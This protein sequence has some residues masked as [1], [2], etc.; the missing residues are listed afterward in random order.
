MGD[1]S[2]YFEDYP[3]ENPG[4]YIDGRYDPH[5]A[6]LARDRQKAVL[7][8]NAEIKKILADAWTEEKK[9]SFVGTT[10]CP[11]CGFVELYLYD[12]KG[13]YHLCE[14]QEC[15]I[16]G[17]GPSLTD[18]L[19]ATSDAIGEG[20]EWRDHPYPFPSSHIRYNKD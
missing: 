2:D 12:I 5:G 4:N 15:G 11:Q 1:W 8:G 16:F 13:R 9:R 14:C 17:R 20:L 19:K 18:A 7:D 6:R 3:E 10:D